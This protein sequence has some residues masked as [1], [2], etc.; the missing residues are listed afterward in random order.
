MRKTENVKI[1]QF[2][3][4]KKALNGDHKYREKKVNFLRFK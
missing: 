4:D 3:N 2:N 1:K